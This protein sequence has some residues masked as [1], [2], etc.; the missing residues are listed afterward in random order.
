MLT[1]RPWRDRRLWVVQ[2]VVL[3]VYVVRLAVEVQVTRAHAPVP[4][5]PDFS[6]LGLFL[7]PVLYAA[8]TVGPTGAAVTTAWVAVL[9]IPRDLAFLQGG[10]PVA[11]WAESTQVAALCLVAVVVGW[12]VAAERA[13]SHRAEQARRAHLAA[14]ARYRALFDASVS[15]TVL[16]DH[17]GGVVELNAAAQALTGRRPRTLGEVVGPAMAAHLLLGGATA[18]AR[19]DGGG[20]PGGGSPGGLG[21]S[22]GG[23]AGEGHAPGD[24]DAAEDAAARTVLVGDR[25]FTVTATGVSAP[26]LGASDGFVQVVLTDVTEEA[27]RRE[28]AEAFAQAV[29]EAQE[30]ERRHLAQELH[31]GPLQSLVH[32]VRQLD[33]AAAG[34]GELRTL[35]MGLV[36]E[37]R[38]IARGLRPSLLDD[39]GLVAAIRRLLDEVGSRSGVETTL[40][41]TGLERRLV[42]ASELTLFRVAQEAVSNAERHAGAGRIAVGLAYEDTGVRLLVTDDGRGFDVQDPLAAHRPGSLGMA[43]MRE[44]VHLVGGALV[45]HSAP[46]AGTTVEAFVPAPARGG[47]LPM[48]ARSSAE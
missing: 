46:G 1:D 22:D 13:A 20:P 8:V 27:R 39:L 47:P 44:R 23:A 21:P 5:I 42:P 14:E 40:G 24:P 12:R 33:G 15:P 38:R 45:V 3:A 17:L 43:G 2:L 28:S 10:D 18:G 26:D 48:R 9:S 25:R 35:G 29:V 4:G 32:L 34:G 41:V 31:D 16:V 11:V 30:E 7:W 6:T 37:L 19:P 36:D